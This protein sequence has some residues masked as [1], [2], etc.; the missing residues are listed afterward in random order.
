M[1]VFGNT[2]I[3]MDNWKKGYVFVNGHN[4]G[5]YWTTVGPDTYVFCPDYWLKETDNEITIIDLE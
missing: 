2:F 5:R 3:H 4:L 1:D